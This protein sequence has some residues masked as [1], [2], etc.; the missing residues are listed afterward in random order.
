[1][2]QE[3]AHTESP[4]SPKSVLEISFG[5]VYTDDSRSQL[6]EHPNV[7]VTMTTNNTA[8]ASNA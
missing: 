5:Y 4:A 6:A 1:M 7:H 3:I 8:T 2:A